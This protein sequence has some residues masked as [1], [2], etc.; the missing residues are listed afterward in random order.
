MEQVKDALQT[1]VRQ[2]ALAP[3]RCTCQRRCNTCPPV[4]HAHDECLTYN[5]YNEPAL[6]LLQ[7]ARSF[8]T[9]P[10]GSSNQRISVDRAIK[11]LIAAI[12][13]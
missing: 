8:L 7:T 2:S 11:K 12:K 4:C 9:G 13:E 5:I 10:I 6:N 1:T 3:N